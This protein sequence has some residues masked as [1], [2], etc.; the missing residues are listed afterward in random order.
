MFHVGIPAPP[1]RRRLIRP[2]STVPF[3]GREI[4]GIVSK[5]PNK[6]PLRP[7]VL[8]AGPIVWWH[9]LPL[10]YSSVLLLGS[11][12]GKVRLWDGAR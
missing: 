2:F 10:P 5:I 11:G 4:R 12:L 8:N 7:C 6:I 1:E 3:S 9:G